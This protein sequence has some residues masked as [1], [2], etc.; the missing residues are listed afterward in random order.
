MNQPK[1]ILGI[2][3][4]ISEECVQMELKEGRKWHEPPW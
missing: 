4:H 1:N 2:K 3:L